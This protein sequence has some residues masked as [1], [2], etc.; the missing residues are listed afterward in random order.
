MLE[1]GC[2]IIKFAQIIKGAGEWLEE[3]ERVDTEKK[4]ALLL[5]K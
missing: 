4:V 1:I 3:F 5:G 2:E